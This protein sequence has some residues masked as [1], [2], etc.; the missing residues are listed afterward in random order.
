MSVR[1][2]VTTVAMAVTA[3]ALLFGGWGLLRSIESTQL[4]QI[5]SEAEH[6]LD[7]IATRLEAGE[8]VD[9]VLGE[10][11]PGSFVQ[12]LDPRGDV[13]V[14]SG[15]LAGDPL[16]V[17]GGSSA[18]GHA[19]VAS[20]GGGSGEVFVGTSAG[21][22][23]VERAL[24]GSA[25]TAV[26]LDLRWEEVV[27]DDGSFT[28]ATASPLEEVTRSLDAVRRSLWF[29]L[30]LLVAL[31]GA[32]AWFVTGRAL[33]PVEAMRAEAEAITHSTLHRRV[34]EPSTADEVGRLAHTM[35]AMLDRLEGSAERQ[36]RFVADASHEL[37]TP[38]ATLRTELEVA[39]RAGDVDALRRGV[40]AALEEEAR[41][42]DLLAD[43][44]LLA[45]VDDVPAAGTDAVDLAALAL[46][47][48]ERPRSVPVEVVGE[49]T[50]R[51][52]RRQLERVVR[53][54]VDNAAHHAAD[55][56][57]VTVAA[58]RLVVE[59]D[60]P[61]VPEADRRRIFERFTRLD[62]GR[63]RDHGG[64]GLGLSIV[65]AVVTAHGGTV[66]VDRSDDLGGARFAVDLPS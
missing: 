11:L 20:S 36:R 44:L 29:G 57:R 45:S 47:E 22:T 15:G 41:L 17:V 62:E 3:V 28:V 60:G 61:G 10:P 55:S 24:P 9:A 2:R 23:R 64:S 65:D 26:P 42:E 12:I 1:V 40:D 58:D 13:L 63:A 16:L 4:G 30:P 56:V 51:G 19:G 14:T 27:T 38:V 5:A 21:A 54:L 46:A 59:D 39:Q 43:L 49:G 66:V 53:N 50:A 33:Q 6:R 32:V 37:R 52:S 8:P 25:G 7:T 34:P 18:A 31:V 48:A 35:N